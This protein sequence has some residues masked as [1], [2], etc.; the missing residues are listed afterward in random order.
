MKSTKATTT[1]SKHQF[2]HHTF[3][4]CSFCF[5]SCSFCSESIRGRFVW[6]QWK[7]FVCCRRSKRALEREPFDRAFLIRMYGTVVM[8]S[9]CAFAM[10]YDRMDATFLSTAGQKVNL[11]LI[12]ATNEN[13]LISKFV[14]VMIRICCAKNNWYSRTLTIKKQRC[15][16]AA[17]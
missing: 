16:E 4:F 8:P 9:Q 14:I 5:G 1:K 10:S 12:L 7:K 3:F 2:A 13:Q 17:G 11:Y 6:G 15:G